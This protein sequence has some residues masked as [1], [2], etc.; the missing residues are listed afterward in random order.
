M[1][2]CL[3]PPA[4]AAARAAA[5]T[6]ARPAAG[7]RLVL[8]DSEG[9]ERIVQARDLV[10]VIFR[11]T[12]YQRTTPRSV[13]A[14]G[15]RIDV[16]DRREDCR[17]VRFG[18]ESRAKFKL[19]R[20]IEIRYPEDGHEAIV[21]LTWRTGRVREVQAGALAAGQSPLPPRFA[22]TID[23]MLREYPLVRGEGPDGSWQDERLVRVLF[24]PEPPPPR[25]R[26]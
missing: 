21:R 20:E 6:T 14:S 23:G 18:D 10:F 12:F 13:D 16:E 22:A 2:L 25:T 11:R 9:A 17:C 4:A 15:R 3:P 5:R 1:L 8:R 26:R 7:P 19:L 24:V